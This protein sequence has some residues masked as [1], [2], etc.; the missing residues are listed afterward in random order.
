[1]VRRIA[2][3]EIEN[4]NDPTAFPFQLSQTGKAGPSVS[5]RGGGDAFLIARLKTIR[6]TI[7][8]IVE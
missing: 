8:R 3:I 1:M 6:L 7:R 4:L 2:R 5:A